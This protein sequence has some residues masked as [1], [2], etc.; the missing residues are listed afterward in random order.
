M[1][2]DFLQ[3]Y[4]IILKKR[5]LISEKFDYAKLDPESIY[6]DFSF[7]NIIFCEGMGVKDN[8]YFSE[9]LSIPIKDII[10]KSSFRSLFP[11]I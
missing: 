7:K 11:K 8:P 9:I 2:M 10:S 3:V 4:S 6:K 1:L 5:I